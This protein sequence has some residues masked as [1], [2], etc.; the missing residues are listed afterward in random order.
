MIIIMIMLVFLRTLWKVP[1]GVLARKNRHCFRPQKELLPFRV[2]PTVVMDDD[3]AAAAAAAD[4]DHD[5]IHHDFTPVACLP[6]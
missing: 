3:D 5:H 2:G 4:H 6:A 1:W